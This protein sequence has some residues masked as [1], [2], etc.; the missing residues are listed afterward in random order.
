MKIYHPEY[1]ELDKEKQ[2][3][4]LQAR[5][6][7]PNAYNI[8]SGFRVA[9][10]VMT[11]SGKIFRS[12]NMENASYGLSICAEPGAIQS[13]LSHGETQITMVAIVGGFTDKTDGLPPLPCGRCR[14]IIS[15]AS[16]IANDDI[17]IISAN[18]GFS[19][20]IV[21]SILELLPAPFSAGDLNLKKKIL[22]FKKRSFNHEN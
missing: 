15:E 14:Q 7:L 18:I 12:C 11:S 10:A 13:A 21:T 9:C 5:E 6:I 2:N 4:L 8:Y 1:H 19:K 20:I 16:Y 3:L 17:E 22:E